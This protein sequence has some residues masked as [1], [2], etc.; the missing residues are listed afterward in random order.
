MKKSKDMEFDREY[1]IRELIRVVPHSMVATVKSEDIE[2]EPTGRYSV[3]FKNLNEAD[4]LQESINDGKT[5][6]VTLK[7]IGGRPGVIKSHILAKDT[8][9]FKEPSLKEQKKENKA[10]ADY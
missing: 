1:R 5:V 2:G 6:L 10:F 4:G 9:E 8:V 3:F 7:E